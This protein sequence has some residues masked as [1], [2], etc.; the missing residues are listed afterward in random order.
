VTNFKCSLSS[1]WRSVRYSVQQIKLALHPNGTNELEA[2]G[3]GLPTL[4]RGERGSELKVV[5]QK[6]KD[7]KLHLV[8]IAIGKYKDFANWV[9]ALSFPIRA[10]SKQ[11][12]KVILATDG[13]K[14]IEK[15]AKS[16]NKNVIMQKDIWHVF[17]QLKY[18]LWKDK[19][20]SGTRSY[21]VRAV[22]KITMLLTSFSPEIRLVI[23]SCYIKLLSYR[24]YKHTAIYLT[25]AMD[26]FYT[27]VKEGNTNLYTSKT[28]RSMR[29]TNQRIN[30]G[31]WSEQGALNV[32]KIR[33][34]Y[35]YN[36]I[37]PFNWKENA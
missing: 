9:K 21:I 20:P 12:G 27:Y 4:N 28:E 34:A 24:G 33:L 18:Y 14:T 29:T 25:S 16:I 2:D 8:G 32:T 10:I 22:Y 11:F 13:D 1:M 30:V 23:L 26:G 17:H 37:N 5:F 6:K 31:V 36:G 7:G 35:Y 19:V 3:T 15:A